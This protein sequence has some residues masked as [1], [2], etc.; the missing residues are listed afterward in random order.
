MKRTIIILLVLVMVLSLAACGE[1]VPK[2]LAEVK[3][4]YYLEES[5]PPVRI[6]MY[7]NDSDNLHVE[8]SKYKKDASSP[9]GWIRDAWSS[10]EYDLSYSLSGD[11]YITVNGTKYYYTIEAEKEF[12]YKR[13]YV[14]FSV[15]F[16]GLG[17]KKWEIG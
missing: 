12:N 17:V 2:S 5:T 9:S 10:S 13:Y 1:K 6:D 11:N 15:D 16:L 4:F 14:V 3:S 7:L 8:L